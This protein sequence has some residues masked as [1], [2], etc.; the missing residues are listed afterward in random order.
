MQKTIAI[1]GM[2]CNN[3][4]NHVEKALT[5][6]EGISSVE[7]SLENKNAVVTFS[8]EVS[9]ETLKSAVLDAGYTVTNIQ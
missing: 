4:K 3:C 9:D 7:V 6:V 5:S 2:M 1:D 8:S